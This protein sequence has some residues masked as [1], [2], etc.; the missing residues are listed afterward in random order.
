MQRRFEMVYRKIIA[1]Y[2]FGILTL[3]VAPTFAQEQPKSTLINTK[4]KGTIKVG[5]E[6]FPLHAVVLKLEEGHQLELTLVSDITIFFEG[7][8][9]AAEKPSEG[10][11]LK[12]K[13]R[14]SSSVEG[15]GKVFLSDDGKSIARMTLKASNKFRETIVRV[16]FEAQ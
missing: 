6:A 10:I 14:A 2:V 16:E 5:R 4:G 9:S 1:S 15:A 7:T 13:G 8:W 3:L 12:I 11:D